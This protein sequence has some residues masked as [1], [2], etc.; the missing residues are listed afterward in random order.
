M[1]I[2]LLMALRLALSLFLIWACYKLIRW[3]WPW[4]NDQK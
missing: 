3:T 1:V 2:I 4:K